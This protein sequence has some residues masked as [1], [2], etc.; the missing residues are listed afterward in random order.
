M[1][2]IKAL[3]NVEQMFSNLSSWTTARR[4]Q[5]S[6]WLSTPSNW[7]CSSIYKRNGARSY[8]PI[9]IASVKTPPRLNRQCFLNP[10]RLQ[11]P[12]DSDRLATSSRLCKLFTAQVELTLI[13]HS[14]ESPEINAPWK[15][16]KKKKQARIRRSPSGTERSC[17]QVKH[18]HKDVVHNA[19]P[20]RCVLPIS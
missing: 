2:S 15:K 9:K 6:R 14:P 10:A 16:R 4:W 11:L 8:R 13:T 3:W 19:T 5:S 18:K 7:T 17:E 1:I 20:A 12:G